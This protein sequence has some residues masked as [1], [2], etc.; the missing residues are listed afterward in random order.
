MNHSFPLEASKLMLGRKS[1]ILRPTRWMLLTVHIYS[2]IQW[3]YTL[4]F[5]NN[6]NLTIKSSAVPL[7]MSYNTTASEAEC[8]LSVTTAVGY[9]TIKNSAAV[10][11]VKL[12]TCCYHH[13]HYIYYT[14]VFPC[15]TVQHIKIQKNKR[16]YFFKVICH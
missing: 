13:S 6:R 7:Y 8:T 2:K 5:I 10:R 11:E 1:E 16:K 15:L 4:C 9:R 3:N 14:T 12:K